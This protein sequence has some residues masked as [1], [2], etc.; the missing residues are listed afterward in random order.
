MADWIIFQHWDWWIKCP[1]MAWS[2]MIGVQCQLV[3]CRG[4]ITVSKGVF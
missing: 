2:S 4:Y 1:L 3:I